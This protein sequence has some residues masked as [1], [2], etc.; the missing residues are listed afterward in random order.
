[1]KK[2]IIELEENSQ[3]FALLMVNS[4][5]EGNLYYYQSNA[6]GSELIDIE[7]EGVYIDVIYKL[8]QKSREFCEREGIFLMRY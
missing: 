2:Y 1:M 8:I 4:N 5:R 6:E 3:I 7:F